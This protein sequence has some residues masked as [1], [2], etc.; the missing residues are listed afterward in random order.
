MFLALTVCLIL[1]LVPAFATD[2]QVIEY[3]WYNEN[4]NRQLGRLSSSSF[5]DGWNDIMEKCNGGF[6]VHV[7][8]MGDWIAD[9]GKFTDDLV[10]GPGFEDDVIRVCEGSRVV[11]DLNGHII[12]RG[13]TSSIK[14]GEVLHVCE[15][16]SLT[17]MNGTVIGSVHITDGKSVSV[18]DCVFKDNEDIDFG[19]ALIVENCEELTVEDCTFSNLEDDSNG[20]GIEARDA[21]LTVNGSVFQNC[22]TDHS[23]S[24]VYAE[25]CT[26]DATNCQFVG[27][28]AAKGGAVA[29]VD[30]EAMFAHCVFGNNLSHGDAG[31]MYVSSDEA[32]SVEVYLSNFADNTAWE[33]GG[34]M[35]VEGKA[36]VA[37]YGCI[38]DENM[39]IGNG[40]A[41]FLEEEAKLDVLDY[42]DELA[43]EVINTRFIGNDAAEKGD[44]FFIDTA[45]GGIEEGEEL[46]EPDESVNGP[47]KSGFGV[48]EFVLLL[49]VAFVGITIV[50][51]FRKPK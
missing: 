41:A 15:G 21:A 43:K 35:V 36:Q 22:S 16:A 6:V 4:S 46:Q 38:V 27:N 5:E 40:G 19:A 17:L 45:D 49:S 34:A 23:G 13:A 28:T 9:G 1:T 26:L 31:A 7:K 11:L 24:A 20:A 30:T 14:N 2:G 32:T 44:V 39:A 3:T 42:N 18:T 10:N 8:L 48:T 51:N 29:L 12:D 25:N 37:L 47:V 33:D 50:L